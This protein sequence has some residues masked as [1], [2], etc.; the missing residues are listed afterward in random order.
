M[1]GTDPIKSH[2]SN[3][4]KTSSS[5]LAVKK[6]LL[7]SALSSFAKVWA[8]KLE[9]AFWLLQKFCNSLIWFDTLLATLLRLVYIACCCSGC[10]NKTERFKL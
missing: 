1:R 10:W 4:S 7:S 6:N 5:F 2:V 3:S 8:G 9:F